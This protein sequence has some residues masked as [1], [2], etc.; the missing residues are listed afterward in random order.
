MLLE[1]SIRTL[2]K[3]GACSDGIKSI[4]YNTSLYTR[5]IKQRIPL[6]DILNSDISDD[7]LGWG[8]RKLVRLCNGA[9]LVLLCDFM[10]KLVSSKK[11]QLSNYCLDKL[12]Y[13]DNPS[14][15]CIR[16]AMT[17]VAYNIE[18]SDC[19][20]IFIEIDKQKFEFITDFARI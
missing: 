7:D 11:L 15:G 10:V 13:A 5:S 16:R 19:R 4:K 6:A 18:I 3:H 8:F 14:C 2:D 9:E 1:I 12:L 20:K 17:L